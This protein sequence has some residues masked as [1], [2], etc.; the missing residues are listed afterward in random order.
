MHD[1]I[2]QKL[3][4]YCNISV[5]SCSEIPEHTINFYDFTFVLSGSMT[6]YA[7][8]KKIILEKDDA[9]FFPPGTV[10]RREQGEKPVRYVSFNFTADA[11]TAFP[12]DL[13]LKKCI[14][15][16][17]RK[18]IS[19]YP[20]SHLAN[21]FHSKEKCQII[22]N[23]IL[24]E[25]LDMQDLSCDNNHVLTIIKYVDEHITEK[26][27]LSDIAKHLFL[28]K[29]YTSHIFKRETGKQ[30]TFYIN[31]QKT[32]LAKKLIVNDGIPPSEVW[33]F[34]GF[35]SYDYFSKTFKKHVGTPPSHFKKNSLIK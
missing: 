30:L 25:L 15:S 8:G 26:I 18:L 14:T 10:R 1:N 9:I 7:N 33:Q 12:F 2:T 11:S 24:L 22:L 21:G 13:F 31:E 23:Y 3:L 5:A 19:V 29:E 6:Y 27:S 35:E 34:L 16:D 28:S 20:W 17:I 4:H 32:R